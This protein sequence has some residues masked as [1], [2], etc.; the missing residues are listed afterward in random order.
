MNRSFT[1]NAMPV[2]H[3]SPENDTRQLFFPCQ[4]WQAIIVTSQLV[5]LALLSILGLGGHCFPISGVR[6]HSFLSP[7]IFTTSIPTSGLRGGHLEVTFVLPGCFHTWKW[8]GLQ[9]GFS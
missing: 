2:V 3:V 7:G 8:L 6:P 9:R 5:T 1:I 4:L